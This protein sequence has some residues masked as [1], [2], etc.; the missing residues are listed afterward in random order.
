MNRLVIYLMAIIGGAAFLFMVKL[1]YDM[2]IHMSRMTDQV[3]VMSADLGRMR[4][5]MG[6]L[7]ADVSGI[8]ASVKDLAAEVS[9]MRAGVD[10]MAGV[11]RT[12]GEQMESLNP[13][14]MMQQMMQPGRR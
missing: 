11:V 2:T 14:E 10:T 9:E 4:G 5:H 13:L 8:G 1:M 3:T 12:T 6:T 7:T